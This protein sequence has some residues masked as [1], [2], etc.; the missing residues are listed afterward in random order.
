M[1]ENPHLLIESSGQ[2]GGVINFGNSG[3]GVGRATGIANFIIGN[4][5]VLWTNGD[6]HCGLSTGG[7]SLRVLSHGNVCI[8]NVVPSYLLSVGTNV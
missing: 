2:G 3:H 4:H 1:S 6:G 8:G 5:V 7:G